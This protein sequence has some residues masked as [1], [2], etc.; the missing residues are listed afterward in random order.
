T[1]VLDHVFGGCLA[2]E[3]VPGEVRADDPV[4]LL[5]IELKERGFRHNASVVHEDVQ[6]PEIRDR[7]LHHERRFIGITDVPAH[8]YGAATGSVY[9][10]HDSLPRVLTPG[11]HGD[12]RTLLR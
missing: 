10:L 8:E 12:G 4:P 6:S 9:L 1:T 7:L 5:A 2:N 11:V 3:K